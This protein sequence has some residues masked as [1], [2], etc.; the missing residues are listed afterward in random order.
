MEEKKLCQLRVYQEHDF[1]V[2]FIITLLCNNVDVRHV[3][4]RPIGDE[5]KKG[6]V[7]CFFFVSTLFSEEDDDLES[8]C[9]KG[10]D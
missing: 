1:I 8:Y 5:K 9:D 6:F 10:M 2:S 3:D 7:K 4:Q